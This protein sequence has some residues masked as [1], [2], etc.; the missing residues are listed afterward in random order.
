MT[1]EL[2]PHVHPDNLALRVSYFIGQTWQDEIQFLIAK[3]E[4]CRE[5]VY[6]SMT[7]DGS[8]KLTGIGRY[9]LNPIGGMGDIEV[10]NG[11]RNQEIIANRMNDIFKSQKEAVK[12]YNLT[13]VGVPVARNNEIAIYFSFCSEELYT[14]IK[15]DIKGD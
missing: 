15:K 7:T 11:L 13:Q 1:R 12:K 9:C 6:L 4:S 8:D 5:A 3:D 14:Q 10:G 2:P